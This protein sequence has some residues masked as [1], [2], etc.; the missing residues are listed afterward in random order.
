MSKVKMVMVVQHKQQIIKKRDEL[1]KI[2]AAKM[3]VLILRYKK[4][5]Q[6]ILSVSFFNKIIN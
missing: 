6:K 4:D 1:S 5:L 2:I 3:K